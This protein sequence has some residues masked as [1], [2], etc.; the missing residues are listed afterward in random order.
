M[1]RKRNWELLSPP[2]LPFIILLE[3]D[4][5]IELKVWNYRKSKSRFKT[6]T[7]LFKW[8]KKVKIATFIDFLINHFIF[9]I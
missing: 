1:M 5:K 2:I 9:K 6:E 7:K 8:W 3:L 4:E